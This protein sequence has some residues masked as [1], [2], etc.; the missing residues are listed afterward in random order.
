M[1]ILSTTIAS[2]QIT[3]T[4]NNHGALDGDYVEIA[5]V[6][7]AVGGI[8]AAQINTSHVI[9]NVATNTFTITTPTAASNSSTYSSPIT[10]TFNIHTGTQYSYAGYGWGSNS[11]GQYGWGENLTNPVIIPARLYSQDRFGNNLMFCIRNGDIYWWNY[12][13]PY[14]GRAV[15]LSSLPGAADVPQ[16]VGSIL[17]SQQDRHLLAFGC[18]EYGSAVYDPLLIRWASQDAPQFWTPGNI[19]VPITGAFSSAGFF[20]LS[21]GSEIV[22]AARTRQE[23]LVFT[24]SSL[25]SIQYTG[26]ARVFN[27]PQ[28]ISNNISIISPSAAVTVNDA[29]YWM[30]VD[31]FYVYNGRVDTLPCTLRQY[32]F[33]DLNRVNAN[34][35]VSG[36]NEQFNELIWFYPSASSI[37]PNRY[38][39]YNYLEQIWYYGS[40]D[41]TAWLDSPLRPIPQGAGLDGWM[42]NHEE[43]VDAAGAPM[44]AYIASGDIDVDDG[45]QFMLIRR[46]IPD[47]NFTGSTADNPQ[48]LLTVNPHNFPGEQYDTTN[49]EGQTLD[50]TVTGT[51]NTATAVIDQ[52]TNQ[53]FLRAR[54]RQIKY[55]ISSNALGV[56]WQMGMPRLDARPDGKRG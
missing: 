56:Q 21:N 48:V 53:V 5:N 25:Y 38:V 51:K 15:L 10:L 19:T 40:L 31:K 4:V 23:I 12:V 50:R 28:Q 20:R 27:D 7:A 35:I 34:Q 39:I 30:G 33:Q 17:F 24:D 43:G 52:Y 16:I 41:R 14:A 44:E 22:C 2:N 42:Y 32:I 18:T 13:N 3:V 9:S 26:D 45:E 49:A 55:K 47:I 29:T 46:I 36:M 6:S 8:P 37:E 11:W 54:G 1:S